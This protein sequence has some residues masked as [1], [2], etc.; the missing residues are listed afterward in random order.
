MWSVRVRFKSQSISITLQIPE[1]TWCVHSLQANCNTLSF[2]GHGAIPKEEEKGP[3]FHS[4]MWG[5]QAF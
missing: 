1:A 4:H 2:E 3:L 5:S